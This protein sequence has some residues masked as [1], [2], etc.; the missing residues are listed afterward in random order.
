MSCSRAPSSESAAQKA[1]STVYFLAA[2]SLPT[3]RCCKEI[4]MSFRLQA[5][6][7]SAF[8]TVYRG[9][10]AVGDA[11]GRALFFRLNETFARGSPLGRYVKDALPRLQRCAAPH[12]IYQ[13][14][15]AEPDGADDK[16]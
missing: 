8:G 2:R 6:E 4:T 15:V 12:I 5:I 16:G 13:V 11:T 9:E 14:P 7:E 10:H 3:C 1:A